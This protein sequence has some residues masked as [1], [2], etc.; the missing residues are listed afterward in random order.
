MNSTP[1]G[2]KK[3]RESTEPE[4]HQTAKTFFLSFSSSSSSSSSDGLVQICDSFTMVLAQNSI[5]H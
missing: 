4:N 3:H 2:T 5:F 1:S